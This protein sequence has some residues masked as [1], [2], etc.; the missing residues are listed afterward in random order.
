MPLSRGGLDI[1]A[2]KVAACFPCNRRKYRKTCSEFV[3]QLRAERGD[4]PLWLLH[5]NPLALEDE[6]STLTLRP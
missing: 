6:E 1:D 5:D 3:A 4:E 2:N